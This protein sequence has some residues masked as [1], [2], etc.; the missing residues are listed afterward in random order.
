MDMHC[1]PSFAGNVDAFVATKHEDFIAQRAAW[2]EALQMD[3]QRSMQGFDQRSYDSD[4]NYSMQSSQS[5]ESDLSPNATMTSPP[6]GIVPTAV[7]APE[8]GDTGNGDLQELEAFLARA[9]GRNHSYWEGLK[10]SGINQPEDFDFLEAEELQ[11]DCGMTKVDAR[12]IKKKLTEE[13]NAR[14]R[15]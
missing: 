4:S 8:S 13:K 10:R 11:S 3:R 1:N 2:Q 9:I 6:A 15:A 14:G 5:S 7:A 12:K